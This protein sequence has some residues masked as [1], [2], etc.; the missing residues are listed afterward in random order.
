MSASE[1]E[2]LRRLTAC[3]SIFTSGDFSVGEPAG[4]EPDE[5]G[6]IQMPYVA[7]SQA[8]IRFVEEMYEVGWVFSFDWPRWS[9]SPDGKRLLSG[10][11]AIASASAVD[12]ARVITTI[13]RA[14][15]FSDGALADAFE[16]GMLTAIARRAGELARSE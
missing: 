7:Y 13:V 16:R 5:H 15:R 1:G 9:A 6:V 2:R 10:P 11:E 12:L 8:T 14:D 3:E 4:G